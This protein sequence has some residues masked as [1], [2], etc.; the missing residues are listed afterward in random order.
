[1]AR[2]ALIAVLLNPAWIT[3]TRLYKYISE[4]ISTLKIEPGDKWLDVGCGSRP[5]E[6]L[7]PCGTYIGVDVAV[8]G[9]PAGMKVPDFFYD[10]QVLPFDDKSVD[11]VLCTQVLEHVRN[12]DM[13]LSEIHRVLNQGGVLILSAPFLWEEHEEPY[14]FLRF[15]SFGFRELLMRANFEVISIQKTTGS[16]ETVAQMLSVYVVNNLSLPIRGCKKILAFF[17]CC[18]IQLVGM[19]LQRLLP[20]QKKLFLDCVIMARRKM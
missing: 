13:L 1:M 9:R 7:F 8:S 10:G 3:E 14:D 18:P 4:A 16:L 12:P 15:T 5:Y 2:P 17:V 19:L 6:S 20:D 11:G